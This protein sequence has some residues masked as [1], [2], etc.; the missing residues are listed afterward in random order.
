M[1]TKVKAKF[2]K[3]ENAKIR[4]FSQILSQRSGGSEFASFERVRTSLFAL[5]YGQSGTK[6][7]L[8]TS[9]PFRLKKM[10]RWLSL[11]QNVKN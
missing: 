2:R 11:V 8:L 9:A 6:K 4:H 3:G 7:A 1:Q 5:F 10:K